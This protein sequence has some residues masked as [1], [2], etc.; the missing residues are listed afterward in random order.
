MTQDRNA[1]RNRHGSMVRLK[2]YLSFTHAVLKTSLKTNL[3]QNRKVLSVYLKRM[4]VVDA[5]RGATVR[6]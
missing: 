6:Q 3:A 2:A 5:L 4:L 1:A